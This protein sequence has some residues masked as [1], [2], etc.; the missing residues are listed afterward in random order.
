MLKIVRHLERRWGLAGRTCNPKDVICGLISPIVII[1]STVGYAALIFSGPL[2]GALPV[3]IGYALIGAGVMAILYAASGAMPYAIAGPDSKLAAVLATLAAIIAADGQPDA[4]SRVLVALLAGTFITGLALYLFGRLK[5]GR[6]I[7][8]IPFP[9]VGGFMA[10]SGWFLAAGAIRVLTGV[11]VTLAR[12][13]ELAEGVHPLQL[14]IGALFC[15]VIH[16]FR[17]AKTPLAF[18]ALLIGGS[19]LVHGALLMAG[20]SIAQ[21]RSAGWLLDAGGGA[22]FPWTGL[23]GTLS[24]TDLG[25]MLRASGEYIALVAVTSITL[26]LSLMAVEVET[27]VDVDVDRELRVNG[28]A[29]LAVG[30]CGGMAGTLSVSRTLFNYRAGARHRISGILAGIVCLLILAFG[31]KGLGYIPVPILGGMLL[32]LG[33]VMLDDWLIKG[34]RRMQPVDFF[35]VLAILLVI[36][37]WDFIAGVVL[38]VMAACI[39]FAVNTSRVRLV[40]L[41]LS[42]SNFGSRV[43]RPALSAGTIAA[44]RQRHPDHVA[45]WFCLFRLGQ[46]SLSACQRNF[47]RPGTEN[48]PL[49]SAGF[50]PGAGDRFVGGPKPG[51]ITP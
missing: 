24:N 3:G 38:G 40:K 11:P 10:A 48:L 23:A 4:Q 13:P 18:P 32:Q 46:P 27:R 30:L 2:A 7:R 41:G 36:V 50:P 29:N 34:W 8:F 35:Q 45:A 39:T 5:T 44:P 12:I 16:G 9:V 17:R 26:L 22:Q 14:L 42:R 37:R 33:L 49:S 15:L 47:G 43:D 31:T 20:Y 28:L 1:T 21:A 25:P 51:E 6:W 19:A